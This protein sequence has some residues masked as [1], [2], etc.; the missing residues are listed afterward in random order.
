MVLICHIQ[1]HSR[2]QVCHSILQVCPIPLE[3]TNQILE[4]SPSTSKQGIQKVYNRPKFRLPFIRKKRTTRFVLHLSDIHLDLKYVEGA[5]GD[6]GRVL[7]CRPDNVAF[8]GQ[9]VKR[10]C[11]K[12]GDYG[13]DT[14]IHMFKSMLKFIPTVA[15]TL[16]SVII[17]GDLI[18]H[19]VWELSQ[20][21]TF[22]ELEETIHILK[23]NLPPNLPIYPVFGN[24]DISPINGFAP[25]TESLGYEHFDTVDKTYTPT[26]RSYEHMA[27]LYS[28]FLSQDA[29]SKF[30]DHGVYAT[31]PWK[32]LKIISLNVVVIISVFSMNFVFTCYV[33]IDKLLLQSEFLCVCS[34]ECF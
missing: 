13:A 17:T 15:S 8:R 5:E 10:A 31:R 25:Q 1:S 7:C 19:N 26:H 6:C 22:S 4:L 34:A 21:L 11:H 30:K 3:L 2:F 28:N 14:S 24:H 32:G 29:I 23:A 9:S 18:P 20:N 33:F 16:D 12:Y 27:S